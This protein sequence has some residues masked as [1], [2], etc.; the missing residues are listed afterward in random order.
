LSHI[1]NVKDPIVFVFFPKK[2]TNFNTIESRSMQL[3]VNYNKKGKTIH[4][5]NHL[6]P[7]STFTKTLTTLHLQLIFSLILIILTFGI[8]F[9]NNNNNNNNNKRLLNFVS[10]QKGNHSIAFFLNHTIEL[11]NQRV[12]HSRRTCFQAHN[13]DISR[14]ELYLLITWNEIM[15]IF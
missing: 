14:V 4:L 15:V 1:L 10:R 12:L 3:Q 13:N 11:F 8:L 9:Y 5:D 6:W 7:R 2:N